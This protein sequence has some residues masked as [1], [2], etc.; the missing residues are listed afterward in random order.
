MAQPFKKNS[1]NNNRWFIYIWIIF[2]VVYQKSVNKYGNCLQYFVAD[3]DGFSLPLSANFL[4]YLRKILC[5]H[6]NIRF[7][8]IISNKIVSFSIHFFAY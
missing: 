6:R 1:N 8:A 3:L 5:F 7:I 2:A 4:R